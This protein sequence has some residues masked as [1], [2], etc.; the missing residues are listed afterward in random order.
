VFHVVHLA[1]GIVQRQDW[2]SRVRRVDGKHFESEIAVDIRKVLE[3]IGLAVMAIP[4]ER[5]GERL[6]RRLI[7]GDAVDL[8]VVQTLADLVED[9]A[10]AM[11]PGLP[12]PAVRSSW[13]RVAFTLPAPCT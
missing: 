7:D 5:R 12:R 4:D 8:L 6:L 11:S 13:A 10:A 3:R 9:P 1:V 2:T